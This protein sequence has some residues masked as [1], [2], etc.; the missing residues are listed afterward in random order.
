MANTNPYVGSNGVGHNVV[1]TTLDENK[2]TETVI[3]KFTADTPQTVGPGTVYNSPLFQTGTVPPVADVTRTEQARFGMFDLNPARRGAAV[4]RTLGPIAEN[5]EY[6]ADGTATKMLG[7]NHVMWQ[8]LSCIDPLVEK[9]LVDN[10]RFWHDRIPRG[11]FQLHDGLVHQSRIF[12]AGLQ[13]YYGLDEWERIDPVPSISNDPCAFPKH[14]SYTYGW[15]QLAW[16]GMR[17]A[18]GSD[19]ICSNA[20][21]YLKDAAQQL[22][23]ILEVGMEQ[24]IQMQE[25]FNRDTYL[26]K[27]TDFGRSYVMTC[28]FHGT[29][30]D[31]SPRYYY[32][33]F[34]KFATTADKDTKTASTKYVD[35]A[36][37]VIDANT[38]IEPINWRVLDKVHELLKLRCRDAAIASD[39]GEP[40]FG[41]MVNTEDVEASIEG[42]DQMYKEW[43]E[44]RTIAISKYN[45]SPRLFRR[46]AIVSDSNQARFKIKHYFDK[47][48]SAE[49]GGV[50]AALEGKPVYIAV[51]VDPFVEDPVH[52]GINGGPLPVENEEYIDAEIAIAP[53][54][55]NDV[56]TNLFETEGT[57][58]LGSGTHFGAYPALNG[59]WGWVQSPQTERDP[60]QQTGKFY[61]LFAI[62]QKPEPR[63]RDVISFVY[64]RCKETL[65]AKCP[66]ENIRINKDANVKE[67]KVKLTEDYSK[68]FASGETAKVE[69]GSV[70][71][72]CL[73]KGFGPMYIGESRTLKVGEVEIPVKVVDVTTI[74]YISVAIASDLTD[75][76]A[77]ALFE[78]KTVSGV[79]TFA[80][81]ELT[82]ATLN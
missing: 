46:W 37:I 65:R 78:K 2:N 10:P 45:L 71:D 27:P 75:D 48:E 16:S 26:S 28:D 13:K 80:G 17:A 67:A 21:R 23:L 22:G 56:L 38:E 14:G 72:L 31:K 70:I 57:V 25:V 82:G 24:G 68:T 34:V 39:G 79:T 50:G 59:K 29:T 61:G 32:D 44:G 77:A 35:R 19:P 11:Q 58:N 47:Y 30:G 53:V 4:G 73:E 74:P 69:S 8:L 81:K 18:W 66:I 3:N 64:R 42:D 20:F 76:Q 5:Y 60:F 40:R 7:F 63:V 55:M 12:R 33:P 15:D 43:L 41:L 36:F 51:A 62:H 6:G 9:K 49:F 54:F 52:K 1:S